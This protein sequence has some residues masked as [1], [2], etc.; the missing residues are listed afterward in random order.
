ME[1]FYIVVLTLRSQY[2]KVFKSFSP[3]KSL[4]F[5]CCFKTS[6][7]CVFDLKIKVEPERNEGDLR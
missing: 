3:F 6:K 7:R 5:R 1:Y 2:L 4:L